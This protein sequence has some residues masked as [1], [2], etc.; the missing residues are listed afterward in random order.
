MP[1]PSFSVR[2]SEQIKWCRVVYWCEIQNIT[3]IHL[4]QAAN[5][6]ILQHK[7]SKSS[8]GKM[9]SK[10]PSTMFVAGSIVAPMPSDTGAAAVVTAAAA[11]MA[12]AAVSTS[13]ATQTSDNDVKCCETPTTVD[14]FYSANLNRSP[15]STK[16]YHN[17]DDRQT[18]PTRHN[19]LREHLISNCQH[20]MTANNNPPSRRTCRDDVNNKY[21]P[22]HKNKRL[23]TTDEH[24]NPSVDTMN[25]R[26]RPL[27]AATADANPSQTK[28][29]DSTEKIYRRHSRRHPNAVSARNR[30]EYSSHSLSTSPQRPSIRNFFPLRTIGSVCELFRSQICPQ[31]SHCSMQIDDNSSSLFHGSDSQLEPDLALLSIVVG[32]IE[33]NMTKSLY[34]LGDNDLSLPSEPFDDAKGA[35]LFVND[36]RRESGSYSP[37]EAT[38]APTVGTSN[39]INSP[40]DFH[41]PT[42]YYETVS[43]LLSQFTT[44]IKGRFHFSHLNFLLCIWNPPLFLSLDNCFCPTCSGPNF[45]SVQYKLV[46]IC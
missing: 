34:L 42:V 26:N 30:H 6:T 33:T 10:S 43:S 29:N 27:K 20:R 41:I 22:K 45:I 40:L 5:K 21:L 38:P 36:N 31:S 46:S 8:G 11:T 16:A 14:Y 9:A 18:Q 39:A 44:Q 7:K 15:S 23:T 17:I 3:A 37:A 1:P 4:P 13:T 12:S 28:L 2:F 35:T 19:N 25:L 24:H 32:I